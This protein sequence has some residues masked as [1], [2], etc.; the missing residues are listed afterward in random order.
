MFAS[1]WTV[2][3]TLL[4]ANISSCILYVRMPLKL[5]SEKQQDIVKSRIEWMQIRDALKGLAMPAVEND[6][7]SALWLIAITW[8]DDCDL[9]VGSIGKIVAATVTG[10]IKTQSYFALCSWRHV[11]GELMSLLVHLNCW[12]TTVEHVLE[13]GQR[14]AIEVSVPGIGHAKVDC[15]RWIVNV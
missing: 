11:S 5:S 7:A 13:G 10:F 1:S 15:I 2:W 8:K 4:I 12:M 6:V 9:V 3:A 14:V